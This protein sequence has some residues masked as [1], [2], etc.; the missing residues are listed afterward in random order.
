MHE[1]M[2]S[3]QP[4]PSGAPRLEVVEVDDHRVVFL[5]G[6]LM[7]R[8][9]CDDKGIERVLVTQLA[10]VLDLADREIASSFGMHPVT[11]SRFRGQLRSGGSA[12][13]IPR[14]TGPKGPS[15]MTPRLEGRCRKL[16]ADGLSSRAIAERVSQ[17][18]TKVSHVTV[19]ALFK[20]ESTQQ[21]LPAAGVLAV[22]TSEPPKE[23]SRA[24]ADLV[25]PCQTRYA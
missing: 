5:N 19:A 8:Y 1:E 4:I 22:A 11:L 6:H 2:P 18:K 21:R 10:E 9:G 23:P 3:D 14:K 20:S 13:L 25:E 24:V 15:K 12:A 16:H 7:G 17:G